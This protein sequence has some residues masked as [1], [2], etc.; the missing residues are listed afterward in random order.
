MSFV[1]RFFW[2]FFKVGTGTYKSFLKITVI[3]FF[4]VLFLTMDGDLDPLKKYGSGKLLEFR[5]FVAVLSHQLGTRYH[6]RVS[7]LFILIVTPLATGLLIRNYLFLIRILYCLLTCK[8]GCA[9]ILILTDL[10]RIRLR[11][12]QKVPDPTGSRSTILIG[13]LPV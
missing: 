4:I 10:F 1:P 13:N 5:K 7:L 9:R 6:I 12:L 3:R 8:K 2:L 11:I